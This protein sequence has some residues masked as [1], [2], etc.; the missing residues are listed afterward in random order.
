MST[1]CEL[2][3]GERRGSEP[4]TIERDVDAVSVD[5]NEERGSRAGWRDER[6]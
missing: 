6:A 1:R 4:L 2:D 5:R 3:G